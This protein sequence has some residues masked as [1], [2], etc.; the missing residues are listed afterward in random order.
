M[1][2]FIEELKKFMAEDDEDVEAALEKEDIEKAEK[3]PDKAMKAIK[4]ALNILNKYKA[5][6][7]DDVLSAIK[8]LAKYAAYG[9]PAK[10]EDLDKAGAKLSKTTRDQL[11]K[12]LGLIKESPKAIAMLKILLGQEVEK[13]KG[14]DGDEKLSEET[15]AKL[16]KLA[17]LEEAEKERIEKAEKE[18]AEKEEKEKQEVLERIEALE[19]KKGIKKS[20]DDP[21]EGDIKKKGAD[22]DGDSK[23]D[24]WPSVYVP[25]LPETED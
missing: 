17:E 20:I 5:D 21:D 12:V 25:G 22:D 2:E 3:V 7:P 10:M 11:A 15:L 9:Y 1:K 18:E 14:G 19:K 23:V 8:T 24:E 6:M 16:E 4:G 13:A